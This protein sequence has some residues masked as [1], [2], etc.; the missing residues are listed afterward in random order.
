MGCQNYIIV[1]RRAHNGLQ[2]VALVRYYRNHAAFADI[3]II[4][5]RRF[6]DCA[7]SS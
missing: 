3:G 6:L 5:Y 2:L 4:H 1:P 7:V